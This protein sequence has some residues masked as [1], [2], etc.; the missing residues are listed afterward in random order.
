MKMGVWA[1]LSAARLVP[2]AQVDSEE[3]ACGFMLHAHWCSC[4]CTHI[5]GAQLGR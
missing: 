5:G 4:L 2:F 3:Y 1:S